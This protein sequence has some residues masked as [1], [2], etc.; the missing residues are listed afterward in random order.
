MGLDMYLYGKRY[1]QH[2]DWKDPKDQFEVELRLGGKP[3]EL[4]NP[5]YIVEQVGYWRKANQ[6]HNWFVKNVQN[7]V[8]DC[9]IYYV[10]EAHLKALL[11]IVREVLAESKLESALITNG[12]SIEKDE[13]QPYGIYKKP[14]IEEGEW[15]ADPTKARELLPAAEGFFFGST[16]YDQYYYRDLEDTVSILEKALAMSGVDFEY[17]SSW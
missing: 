16:A 11:A 8:D 5:T 6:I 10:D 1:I 12:Y 15:I 14:I 9:G 7:G 17:H 13:T 3:V 2:W 4:T